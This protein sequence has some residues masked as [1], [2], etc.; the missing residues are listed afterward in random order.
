MSQPPGPQPVHVRPLRSAFRHPALRLAQTLA[1][2]RRRFDL[3]LLLLAGALIIGATI[4]S[5]STLRELRSSIDWVTHTLRVKVALDQMLAQYNEVELFQLVY[6]LGG[7]DEALA[8]HL[9]ARRALDDQLVEVAR[10]VQDNPQQR[11][12]LLELNQLIRVRDVHYQLAIDERRE[13]G[14][15]AASERV[16]QASSGGGFYS[17]RDAVQGMSLAEQALLGKRQSDLDGVIVQS[18]ATVLLVNGLAL[19]IAGIALVSLRRSGRAASEQQLA[20][21]RAQEAERVSLEKSAFLASMSHEIRTPMNA[22][23]GF[24][25]LLARTQIEPKAQEYIRAIQTSGKA[26]LALINDILDLSRIEAGKLSLSP[27]VTDLRELCDAMLSVFAEAAGRKGLTLRGRLSPNLPRSVVLDPHRLQ[28]VL[29]NLLSNAIKYTNAGEVRFSAEMR[30][31]EAGRCDLLFEVHDTGIGIDPARQAQ[32]FEPFYRA[33]DESDAEPGAGLGLAIVSRLLALM[34][35]E[36]EAKSVPAGGSSFS[37][38]LHDVPIGQGD[39]EPTEDDDARVNFARL[40]SSRILIVDDVAWNREL[41]AAFLAEGDHQ[42]A[43]ASN[44]QQALDVAAE[45]SPDVVLMDLRM[46]V[47]DGR[48]ATRRLRARLGEQGPAVI[49]VSASSMARE[50]QDI[51]SEFNGFV[52]KPVSREMLFDALLEQVGLQQAPDSAEQPGAAD[53]AA[54]ALDPSREPAAGPLHSAVVIDSAERSAA[55]ARLKEIEALELAPLLKTLRVGEIRRLA[56]ELTE[57]ARAGQLPSIGYFA[58]RLRSALDRFDIQQM[59]SLLQQLPEH[60]GAVS[61]ETRV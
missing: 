41:L 31:P 24:S 37:V 38:L 55:L 44:G 53:G 60:I 9:R 45:F 14:L 29:G 16:H 42:V 35:G 11:A 51:E 52:R 7:R 13:L 32:L 1:P 59:E 19:V 57:L 25:Q 61:E 10:L 18:T 3:G 36:I 49:A 22:V 5:F 48:E 4:Y 23:F 33:V 43:F 46:P 34:N 2:S 39:A 27:Q 28:Q 26:L 8:G 6:R 50:E 58:R 47:L 12:R 40:A 17:I 21:V 30:A 54:D 15:E 56:M 20:E